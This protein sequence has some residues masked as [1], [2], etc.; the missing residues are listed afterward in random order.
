MVLHELV[1]DVAT[2]WHYL[3]QANSCRFG[4]KLAL[5]TSYKFGHQGVPLALVSILATR[6]C[7]FHAIWTRIALLTS[8]V[9]IELL[10][11]SARVTSV[12]SANSLGVSE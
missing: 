9:G 8:A 10:S 11:S 7:H 5:L 2:R 6:W 4:Q 3:H 12:K 1:A